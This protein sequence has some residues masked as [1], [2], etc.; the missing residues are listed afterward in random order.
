MLARAARC[1]GGRGLRNCMC[2]YIVC[3]HVCANVCVCMCVCVHVCLH[4]CVRVVRFAVCVTV[5]SLR[6]PWA[7]ATRAGRRPGG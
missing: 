2:V 7:P 4:V 5:V 1:V 3:V 6:A